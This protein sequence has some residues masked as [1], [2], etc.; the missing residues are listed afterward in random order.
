MASDRPTNWPTDRPTQWL[1]YTPLKTLF[2]G[3]YKKIVSFVFEIILSLCLSWAFSAL[4]DLDLQNVWAT[5]PACRKESFKKIIENRSIDHWNNVNVK[6]MINVS[7]F[8][9]WMA[10]TFEILGSHVWFVSRNYLKEK[11]FWKSVQWS[12]K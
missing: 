5:G 6:L 2:F 11:I 4:N 8:K 3:G 10:L 12:L 9:P 1:L 7:Y